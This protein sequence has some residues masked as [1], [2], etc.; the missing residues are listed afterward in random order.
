MVPI[1]IIIFI[2]IG[3]INIDSLFKHISGLRQRNYCY[4]DSIN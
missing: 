1:I 2:F 3:I 4:N